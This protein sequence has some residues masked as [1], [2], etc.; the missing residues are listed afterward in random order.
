MMQ[1][2]GCAAPVIATPIGIYIMTVNLIFGWR[3]VCVCV[4]ARRY[5]PETRR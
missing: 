1:F 3:M 4:R 5:F 2:N